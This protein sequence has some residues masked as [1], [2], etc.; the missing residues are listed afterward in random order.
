MIINLQSYLSWSTDSAQEAQGG[1]MMAVDG[2]PDTYAWIIS[3]NGTTTNAY[4][5]QIVVGG[6]SVYSFNTAITKGKNV[7][8]E[9][10]TDNNEIKFYYYNS[11]WV[12]MGTTQT[13][14]LGDVLYTYMTSSDNTAFNGAN[15]I[16]IDDLY[17]S[18]GAYTS[19]TPSSYVFTDDFTGTTIDTA[20]WDETDPNGRISQSGNLALN[21]PHSSNR[22][23]FDDYLQSVD[24]IDSTPGGSGDWTGSLEIQSDNTK[25]SGSSNLTDY[26]ALIADGNLTSDV[27]A[28]L[29]TGEINDTGYL[30]DSTLKAYYRFESG[31]L[32]TDT[33]GESHTLSAIATPT[34]TT[35]KFGGGVALASASSQAYSATDHADFKPTGNFSVTAWVKTSTSGAMTIF[36]SYSQNTAVAGIRLEI[37]NGQIALISGKNSGTTLNTDFVEPFTTK[38]VNDGSWHHLAGTWDGST[39]KVYIDGQLDASASWANAPVYGGTSYVRVGTR[40]STGTNFQFWDGDLDDI[41]Y[42]M[43]RLCQLKMFKLFMRVDQTS[44]SPQT[45]QVQQKY[46]LK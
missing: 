37:L 4:R 38:T 21:N 8:I 23:Y 29:N 44:V 17:F 2:T 6:S 1:L 25:V 34:E 33:S 18:K 19:A 24:S 16:T 3:R 35:G 10:N 41:A 45:Q 43:E 36:Q 28:G 39:V 40:N 7:K 32:T 14:D 31:A 12:Q 11:G 15:P 42:L 5:L 26:P 27:Y 9:Y 20:K 46:L 22:A 13:Y 30:N